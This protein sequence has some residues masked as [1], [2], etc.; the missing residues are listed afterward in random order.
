MQSFGSFVAFRTIIFTG[1]FFEN[2]CNKGEFLNITRSRIKIL[3]FKDEWLQL[4]FFTRELEYSIQN[5]QIGIPILHPDG[6]LVFNLG[7]TR[8]HDQYMC[9]V[10]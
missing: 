1:L 5:S 4:T 2:V 6:H 10:S 3:S 7:P 8:D 9:E